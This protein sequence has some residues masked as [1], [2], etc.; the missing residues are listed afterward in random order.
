MAAR[1]VRVLEIGAEGARFELDAELDDDGHARAFFA[2]SGGAHGFEELFDE[3]P[4]PRVAHG[5]STWHAVLERH[6]R[7]NRWLD[8][9]PL[10]VH[11]A[12]AELVNAEL[13]QASDVGRAHWVREVHGAMFR[14][15]VLRVYAG[16]SC[17]HPYIGEAFASA[18]PEALRVMTIGINAYISEPE[19]LRQKPE[20]FAGWFAEG[21]HPFDRKVAEDASAI[22]NA[23]VDG[24]RPFAGLSFRGKENFFHT[25]A[26]KAYL[27]AAVGKRSDQV[28]SVE[29]ERHV[30]TWHAELDIMAKFGVL[31]HV[32]IVFGR[33]FWEH[34][35][36][37]FHPRTT[38]TFDHL[39]V[40]AFT[41][42]SGKGHHHANLIDVEGAAGKHSLALLALRHPAAR[43]T[44]K[45]TPSW[46]LSLPD[47]RAML[48]MEPPEP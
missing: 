29:Y 45:A 8:L 5:P 10:L 25:N 32:V 43:A 33:P 47:V 1:R 30:P 13:R 23:L 18:E 46:L 38:P 42:A 2:W 41:N 21:R 9:H 20:W 35:W 39:R 4:A 36:Q 27:P 24:A 11:P 7:P 19:W 15:E 6:L 28:A 16:E 31:P 34:A 3:E 17:L 37:A 44:S 22:A 12:I 40:H 26:V 14:G 48:G